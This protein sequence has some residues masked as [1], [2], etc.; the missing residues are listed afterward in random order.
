M[1]ASSD[2]RLPSHASLNKSST[3][4]QPSSPTV[5]DEQIGSPLKVSDLGLSPGERKDEKEQLDDGEQNKAPQ[6]MNPTSAAPSSAFPPFFRSAGF[7]GFPHYPPPGGA[8]FQDPL[9]MRLSGGYL[10]SHLGND[11]QSRQTALLL[12]ELDS[13]KA[14]NKKVIFFYT[15]NI[16]RML[17]YDLEIIVIIYMVHVISQ[18]LENYI[19]TLMI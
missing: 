1:T 11:G 10:S 13:E 17:C 15:L 3:N 6:T 14:K 16:S 18:M 12:A 7:G 9:H 19:I 8:Y 4:G 5:T 2:I